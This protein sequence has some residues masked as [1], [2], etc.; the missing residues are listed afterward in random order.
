LVSKDG[1]DLYHLGIIDF[2]QEWN[3]SKAVERFWK[4]WVNGQESRNLSA[5]EPKS[6]KKRF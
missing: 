1:K 6:Y 5:I 2:L 4:H 3:F